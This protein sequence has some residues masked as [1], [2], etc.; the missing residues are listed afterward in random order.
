MQTT[1]LTILLVGALERNVNVIVNATFALGVT[2]LPGVL[3]R[4]FDV[5]LNPGLALFITLAV[6]LHSLG[7]A[8]FYDR[9]W[10]WDHLTHVLSASIVATVGYATT[11]ALDEYS[12][13]VYFPDEFLAVFVLLVTI[14]LGV[15]WELVEHGGREL[16]IAVGF[17]PVLIVYGLEDTMW[18]LVFDMIGGMVGAIYASR[19]LDLTTATL[20]RYF[21]R[22]SNRFD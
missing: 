17:E 20:Q 22:S 11:R 3:A 21:E 4:D 19:R 18:D 6:L 14:A 5:H 1:I 13:A 16:A 7:M 9:F 12:E 2:L 10:W 15:L 8:G